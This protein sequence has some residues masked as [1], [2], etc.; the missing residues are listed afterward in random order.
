MGATPPSS[1]KL[2]AATLATIVLS[3]AVLVLFGAMFWAK[4]VARVRLY[5]R[6]LVA[7][8]GLM[9]IGA[10]AYRSFFVA[11]RSR[12]PRW[13]RAYAVLI[14]MLAGYLFVLAFR[15]L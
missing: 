1:R 6:M 7:V 12:S 10:A 4:D 14:L 11:A 9:M 3:A 13:H 15:G 5:M 8:L 2:V